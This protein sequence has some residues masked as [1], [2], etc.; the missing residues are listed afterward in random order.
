MFS[1]R[2][3]HQLLLD[4]ISAAL[5]VLLIELGDSVPDRLDPWAPSIAASPLPPPLA[6]R[7][8]PMPSRALAATLV[9]CLLPVCLSVERPAVTVSPSAQMLPPCTALT[10]LSSTELADLP[11]HRAVVSAAHGAEQERVDA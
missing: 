9:R 3:D 5:Q 10:T 1:P 11:S 4:S 6:Q 8:L 7:D 2:A